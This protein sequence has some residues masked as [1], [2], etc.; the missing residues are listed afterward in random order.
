MKK[1]I[2]GIALVLVAGATVFAIDND[3]IRRKDRKCEKEAKCC[4]KASEKECTKEEKAACQKES[5]SCCSKK[6][7]E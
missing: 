4:T 1:I 7:S 3:K 6:A 5:K 2:I